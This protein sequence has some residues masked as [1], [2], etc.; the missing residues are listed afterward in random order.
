MYNL[1]VITAM[2]YDVAV[3]YRHLLTT[4]TRKLVSTCSMSC[5]PSTTSWNT[6]RCVCRGEIPGLYIYIYIYI[7]RRYL[8]AVVYPIGIGRS[9]GFGGGGGGGNNNYQSV[10][11]L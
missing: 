10:R 4:P 2:L 7:A 6:S 9:F 11:G 8:N 1:S 5:T 3:S